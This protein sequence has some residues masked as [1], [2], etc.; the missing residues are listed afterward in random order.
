MTSCF[1]LS[2]W[3]DGELIKPRKK[4]PQI[5]KSTESTCISHH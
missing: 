2:V 3:I 1:Y 4:V 5:D